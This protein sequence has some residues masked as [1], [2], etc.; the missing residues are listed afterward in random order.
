M[1]MFEMS[2]AGTAT[3][4]AYDIYETSLFTVT[5][6]DDSAPVIEMP[7]EVVPAATLI[8]GLTYVASE[9]TTGQFTVSYATNV[10]TIT[11][12]TGDVARRYLC[13]LQAQD[14]RRAYRDGQFRQ[15]Q[16]QGRTC[17]ACAGVFQRHGLQRELDQGLC[18]YLCAAC[19]N[20][21]AARVSL[22]AKPLYAV[23]RTVLSLNG[24]TLLNGRQ[25][26]VL[27]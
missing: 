22:T 13:D 18:A 5:N 25:P 2:N 14:R 4:G 9:A 7:F 21:C 16:R 27:N 23:M 6:G 24:E 20:F 1:D 8:R 17:R 19:A 10:S 11:F 15:R 12:V 26:T 3:D